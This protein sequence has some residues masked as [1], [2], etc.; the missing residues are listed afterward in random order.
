MRSIDLAKHLVL[1]GVLF[2]GALALSNWIQ[3]Y[4]ANYYIGNQQM[5]LVEQRVKELEGTSVIENLVGSDSIVGSVSD[6][7]TQEEIKSGYIVGLSVAWIPWFVLGLIISPIAATYVVLVV[8]T[9]LSYDPVW[10]NPLIFIFAF[11]LGVFLKRRKI[12]DGQPSIN[13]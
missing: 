9:A 11:M 2:L 1:V 13:E 10:F 6:E 5:S 8:V 12:I 7:I 3:I 4:A